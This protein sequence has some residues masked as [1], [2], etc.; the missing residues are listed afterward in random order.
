MTAAPVYT[1]EVVNAYPHDSDAFTEGL[2]FD[3]GFLYES[4]GLYGHSSLRRV[5]LETGEVLQVRVL[6]Y[7]YFG[8]GITIYGDKIIQLTYQSEVGFVYNKESFELLGEFHYPTEG[9]G[10]TTDGKRLIMSDGTS[11][12]HFLDPETFEEIGH[13]DVYDKGTPVS[14]LNELEY[15]NGE[16]YANVWPTDSIAIIAPESGQVVGWIDLAGL[17]NPRHLVKPV[18]VLNGIAYDQQN[19]RLF[20]TGKLWPKLFEIKLIRK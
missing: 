20:V 19:D 16:L 6:P 17:L 15:V 18:D 10:I 11:T 3:N 12:L 14:G 1:Y 7:Q 2:A 5:S 13:I 8:E 9:W 4:T